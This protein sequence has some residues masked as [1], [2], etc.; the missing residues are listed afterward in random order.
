MNKLYKKI[1]LG[2]VGLS[3]L[4]LVSSIAAAEKGFNVIGYDDNKI[5]VNDIN[6]GDIKIVEPKLRYLLKKNTKNLNFT[7]D[8]YLLQSCDL[9][10]ISKDVLTDKH[11]TS[12]FTYLIFSSSTIL[13]GLIT[14]LLSA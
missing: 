14:L 1:S 13:T 5:L 6:N 12:P 10:Y 7:S 8:R 2:F 4:G 3:H 11:D 9:V